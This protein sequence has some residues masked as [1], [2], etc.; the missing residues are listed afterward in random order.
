VRVD[1]YSSFES[2]LARYRRSLSQLESH[3]IRIPAA[4]RLRLYEK[5]LQ[6]VVGDGRTAIE[7][8]LVYAVT[9]D[10]REMDEL[11]EIVSYLPSQIDQPTL[12]LLNKVCGGN[13]HPS[14]WEN[15]TASISGK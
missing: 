13:D 2:Q 7:S 15:V 12:E 3:G 1:E 9:F 6:Q 8:E 5:R 14:E 11:I 10:L 4:S